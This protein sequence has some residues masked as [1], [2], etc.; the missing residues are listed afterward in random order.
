MEFREAGGSGGDD[1]T[2]I[3]ILV[4]VEH[5]R[6]PDDLLLVDIRQVAALDPGLPVL[7]RLP[8]ELLGSLLQRRF[9]RLAIGQHEVTILIENKRFSLLDISKGNIGGKPHLLVQVRITDMVAG[10]HRLRRHA[11]IISP[12]LTTNG[13]GGSAFQPFDLPHQHQRPELSLIDPHPRSA[14]LYDEAA[15][16]THEFR[17]KHIGVGDIILPGRI[18]AIRRPD[19]EMAAILFVE[20]RAEKKAAVESWKTHPFYIPPGIDI[21][22]VRAITNDAYVILMN[23]HIL[24]PAAART[25]A[26]RPS[27]Y[28]RWVTPAVATEWYTGPPKRR[29]SP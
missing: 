22:K 2:R 20:Q 18:S 1:A 12:R 25:A 5:E 7:G 27:A 3:F 24:F 23:R 19:I 15:V 26:L 10:H 8:D 4:H 21:G 14:V 9:Q 29:Y 11:T 13:D 16:A 28:S 6:R 17:T